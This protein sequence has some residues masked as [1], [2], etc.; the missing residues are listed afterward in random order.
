MPDYYSIRL[1]ALPIRLVNCSGFEAQRSPGTMSGVASCFTKAALQGMTS[2]LMPFPWSD[3][4]EAIASRDG[5]TGSGDGWRGRSLLGRTSAGCRVWRWQAV[6]ECGLGGGA[7]V[8]RRAN[9]FQREGE[10]RGRASERK[11]NNVCNLLADDRVHDEMCGRR[12]Y[13]SPRG[14]KRRRV[15]G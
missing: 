6:K 8:V 14:C 15:T 12:A 1:G 2:F 10:A 5:D 7:A 3:V 4:R 13:R 11:C 9:A